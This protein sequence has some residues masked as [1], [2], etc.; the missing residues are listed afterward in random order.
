MKI[1]E[2][3]KRFKEIVGEDEKYR[4]KRALLVLEYIEKNGINKIKSK[5]LDKIIRVYGNQ[6]FHFS[7]PKITD[8]YDIV[9]SRESNKKITFLTWGMFVF[10]FITT[11]ATIYNLFN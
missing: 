4:D 1:K 7:V 3:E 8:L 10:A 6:I 5:H 2:F 9:S 11:L